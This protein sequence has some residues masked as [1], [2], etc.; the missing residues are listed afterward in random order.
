MGRVVRSLGC[1]SAGRTS[2]IALTCLLISSAACGGSSGTTDRPP[3]SSAAVC[4]P[5]EDPAVADDTAARAH[6]LG[7]ELGQTRGRQEADE[8]ITLRTRDGYRLRRLTS[9]ILMA[10]GLFLAGSLLGGLILGFLSRRPTLRYARRLDDTIDQRLNALR[11]LAAGTGGS[12]G[13]LMARLEKP[14]LI[15]E[16]RAER[17]LDLAA[18]LEEQPESE[19]ARGQLTGLYA[20]LEALAD[21]VERLHLRA[22]GWRDT[23][24]DVDDEV[25]E[26]AAGRHVE[27]FTAT[28]EGLA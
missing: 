11:A 16:R 20:K 8:H 19:L 22:T 21:A 24:N 14:L 4:T 6:A 15:A 26:D 17:L 18:P 2:L 7:R 10:I 13:R 5:R 23:L 27:A 28:L 9:T 12:A 25:A 1:V 3:A